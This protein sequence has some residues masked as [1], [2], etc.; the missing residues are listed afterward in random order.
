[1]HEQLF[2]YYMRHDSRDCYVCRFTPT[3]DTAENTC[4]KNSAGRASS[5]QK[6]IRSFLV[7]VVEF[8]TRR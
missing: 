2:Y 5:T 1:M 3:S 4:Q 7:S 6:I 8:G